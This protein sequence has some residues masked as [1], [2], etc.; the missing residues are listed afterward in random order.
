MAGRW[1]RWTR[2]PLVVFAGVAAALFAVDAVLSPRVSTEPPES[3]V[4]ALV[5]D[6]EQRVGRA[7]TPEET[8]QLKVEWSEAEALYQEGLALG[9]DRR[10]PVVRRRVIAKMEALQQ[11]R[12]ASVPVDEVELRAFF[13]ANEARYRTP[14]LVRYSLTSLNEHGE[15]EDRPSPHP[16]EGR[17]SVERLR[18]WFGPEVAD[19]AAD[20]AIGQAA[21]LHT[22]QGDVELRVAE[23]SG[24]QVPK[25]SAVRVEVLR[26]FR[27]GAASGV[28]R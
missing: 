10:D 12:D 8:E 19:A 22:R 11:A 16:T 2:E 13:E 6:F 18:A 7:P 26:D 21:T 9:L 3:M 23:R 5:G 14:V 4:R 24:G 27:A 1:V 25:L 28:E 17:A 15:P 20:G